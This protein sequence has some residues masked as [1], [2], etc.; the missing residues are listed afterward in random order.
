FQ[1][2]K[3]P[4]K[5]PFDEYLSTAKHFVD[6][7]YERLNYASTLYGSNEWIFF[8]SPAGYEVFGKIYDTTK[9]VGTEFAR[10]F[11]RI[12]TGKDELYLFEGSEN[13]KFIEGNFMKDAEQRQIERGILKP[14]VKGRSVHRYSPVEPEC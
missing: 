12:A 11:Q 9:R 6:I 7:P 8:S 2:A 1:F 4:F 10:V 14:F 3:V 5:E 13:G